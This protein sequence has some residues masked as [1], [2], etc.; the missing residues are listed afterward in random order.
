MRV[1][2]ATCKSEFDDCRWVILSNFTT[3]RLYSKRRGQVYAHAFNLADLANPE[4][5]RLF[6]FL[7]NRERLLGSSTQPSP[8]DALLEESCAQEQS[9][10][11]DFYALFTQ[12]R[13]DLFDAL[14]RDNP[15][16]ADADPAEHRVRILTL[17]QK[18]LDRVL[19][20][21]TSTAIF[22]PTTSTV[23]T[24][25]PSRWKSPNSHCGSKPPTP[26]VL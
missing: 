26:T 20:V 6:L 9:I 25:V 16:P 22:S 14:C 12:V 5:L 21:S 13:S 23:W 2:N 19:F 8:V 4:T 7:L 24:S 3:L 15:L 1:S 17:T 10:T 11:R 18:I